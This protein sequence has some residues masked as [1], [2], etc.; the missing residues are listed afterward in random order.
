VW[1]VGA[2]K[3]IATLTGH[4]N[5]V[6]SAAFN[7][8]GTVLVTTGA[9]GTTR[10]WDASSYQPLAVLAGGGGQ[11]LRAD[12]SPDGLIVTTGSDGSA[13]LYACRFCE[14]RTALKT[15]AHTMVDQR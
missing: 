9:D 4:A 5:A 6:L 15:L 12:F 7:R 11:V 1:D 8:D 14:S 2:R 13:R 10:I 3:R